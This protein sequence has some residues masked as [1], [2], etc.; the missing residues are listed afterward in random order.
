MSTKTSIRNDKVMGTHVF[1][2]QDNRH[3][4]FEI[5]KNDTCYFQVTVFKK[6]SQIL[7]KVSNCTL[8]FSLCS[9]N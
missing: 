4:T 7:R 6:R 2:Q 8:K 9:S 5:K 3:K 1:L